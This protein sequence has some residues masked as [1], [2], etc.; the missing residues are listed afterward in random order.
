MFNVWTFCVGFQFL[1]LIG[2]ILLLL[3]WTQGT[4][5]AF[6]LVTAY[7]VAG[8]GLICSHIGIAGFAV[9]LAATIR[10]QRDRPGSS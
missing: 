1:F 6:D 4:N 2:V 3:A 8:A 7:R 5:G 10:A 9:T